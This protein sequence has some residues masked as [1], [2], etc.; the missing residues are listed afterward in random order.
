VLGLS[1][2]LALPYESPRNEP[3]HAVIE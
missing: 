1:V 3:Q 2:S